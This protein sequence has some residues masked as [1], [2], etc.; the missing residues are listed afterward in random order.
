M[1]LLVGTTRLKVEQLAMSTLGVQKLTSGLHRHAFARWLTFDKP[2]LSHP[3]ASEI[4]Y[5]SRRPS[6]QSCE[7]AIV[8]QQRQGIPVMCGDDTRDENRV[9]SR[10]HPRFDYTFEMSDASV[11]N[12]RA[13]HSRMIIDPLKRRVGLRCKVLRQRDLLFRQH[14]DCERPRAF[15]RS[16]GSIALVDHHQ[17][18]RWLSRDAADRCCSHPVR[19]GPGTASDDRHS[20]CNAPHGSLEMRRIDRDQRFGWGRPGHSHC[21]TCRPCRGNR[22]RCCLHTRYGS[23]RSSAGWA[24]PGRRNPRTSR[25]ETPETPR[26]RPMHQM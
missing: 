24:P 11:Q 2:A 20:R 22:A 5:R 1:R 25:A 15:D 18:A 12:G 14:V 17:N 7:V 3:A 16:V 13:R 21:L 9:S 4:V 19:Q 6:M 23:V 10:G 8:I 26:S